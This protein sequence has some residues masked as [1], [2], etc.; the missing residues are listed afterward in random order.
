M[1]YLRKSSV[2]NLPRLCKLCKKS[3]RALLVY[4][5]IILESSAKSSLDLSDVKDPPEIL[6]L[7]K[8]L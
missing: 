2:S 4:F 7:D 5:L 6:N 3:K 1:Y 8:A